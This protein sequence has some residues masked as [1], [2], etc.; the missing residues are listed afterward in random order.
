MYDG[1]IDIRN[2]SRDHFR[3]IESDDEKVVYEGVAHVRCPNRRCRTVI[4]NTHREGKVRKA[5]VYFSTDRDMPGAKVYQYYS[6]RYR[7]EFLFRDAKGFPGLEDT[8]SRQE[9]A[10]DFHY[11]LSLSTL[12]VAKAHHW[13]SVPKG[14]RGVFSMA[15]IKTQYVNEL[16]LDRLISIYG[17]DPSI[18]KMNPQIMELYQL[19]RIAA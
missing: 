1:K 17:K 19:G 18:E 4:V 12:N 9:K 6:M 8:Q 3:V 5:F 10:L 13:L 2:V 16:L 11:N 7:I 14:E 15:D